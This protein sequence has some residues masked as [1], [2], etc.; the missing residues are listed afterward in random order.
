MTC[1]ANCWTPV[2][3][4]THG[5]LM[6]PFGRSHGGYPC[7]D[8]YARSELNPRHLWDEHDSTRWYTDP[9]GWNAHEANCAKCS[10]QQPDEDEVSTQ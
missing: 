1:T 7:C 3:C 6:F 9:A 5:G 10:P 4:P 8:N 2:P